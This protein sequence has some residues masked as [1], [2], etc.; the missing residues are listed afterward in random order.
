MNNYYKWTEERLTIV[1]P[2]IVSDMLG[3]VWD[4][5]ARQFPDVELPEDDSTKEVTRFENQLSES[6][7]SSF[8]GGWGQHQSSDEEEEFEDSDDEK[9]GSSPRSKHPDY[10]GIIHCLVVLSFF[11]GI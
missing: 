9:F 6:K 7:R 1:W 11:R 8:Y 10:I 3:E 2:E 5:F 4:E